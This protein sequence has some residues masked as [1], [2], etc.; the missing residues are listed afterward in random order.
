MI[1]GMFI[2]IPAAGYYLYIS[3]RNFL[4][5]LLFGWLVSGCK[6]SYRKAPV[7]MQFYSVEDYNDSRFEIKAKNRFFYF[8]SLFDS[9][10]NSR[11]WGKY[12]RNGDTLVLQFTQPDGYNVLGTKAIIDSSANRITFFK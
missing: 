1:S 3:M 7:Q 5:I 2:P 12:H 10:P 4:Y 8:R 9:I 11:Y 6:T